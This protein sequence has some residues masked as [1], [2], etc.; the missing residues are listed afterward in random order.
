V[1]T[2]RV[3]KDHLEAYYTLFKNAI[4]SPAFKEE[5]FQRIKTRTMNYLRQARRFSNDEELSKE[6]L[7]WSVY[8]GTPYQHPEEGRGAGL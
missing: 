4:L 3:H 2:G 6:L 5:D 8:R 1:F 7:F